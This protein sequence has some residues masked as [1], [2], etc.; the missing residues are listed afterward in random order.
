MY[1][2]K[3]LSAADHPYLLGKGGRRENNSQRMQGMCMKS[4]SHHKAL[5]P[6]FVIIGAGMVFV[7][8]YIF[9]LASKT[10]DINWL[11]HKNPADTYGYY[12]E[13]QFQMFNPCGTK[14]EGR[15]AIRPKYE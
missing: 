13:R 8:A 7:G 15:A 12:E 3:I 11:K 4:L 6:L 5:Q 14:Y 1:L 10:T 2:S 9:R